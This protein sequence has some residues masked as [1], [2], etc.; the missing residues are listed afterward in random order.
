MDGAAVY[1]SFQIERSCRIS[2]SRVIAGADEAG[3]GALA[4][5][6][7]VGIVVF[8]NDLVTSPPEALFAIRDSKKL[9]AKKRESAFECITHYAETYACYLVEPPRIDQLNVNQAT[10]YALETAAVL[11][12]VTPDI[13]LL[14]GNFS[15]STALPLRSVVGGDSRSISIAA[16][17]I[18]AKVTRDRFMRNYAREYPHFG[19]EHNMGYG[20][21]FHREAIQKYGPCPGHRLT[22]E[23]VRS[24]YA[25]TKPC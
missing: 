3:R 10:L 19:F 13:I 16:A 15:F 5:P 11:L 8:N 24:L 1:P 18:V 20:T 6:L 17:S 21:A 4:G 2:G 12:T 9:S 7:A 22:Y 25:D 23:P 14:D